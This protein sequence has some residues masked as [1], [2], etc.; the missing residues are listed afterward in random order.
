MSTTRKRG[1]PRKRVDDDMD[2]DIIEIPRQKRKTNNT[3]R[4]A[5]VASS[6]AAGLTGL[7]SVL[8]K[9]GYIPSDREG[10]SNALA[11]GLQF[12]RQKAKEQIL[13]PEFS[14]MANE[15]NSMNSRLDDFQNAGL[16]LENQFKDLV[17]VLQQQNLITVN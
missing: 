11:Q 3:A 17:N 4:N 15:V 13:D 10:I 14:T 9:L 7:A 1:R 16:Q 6:V 8:M 12:T 5:V 2:I